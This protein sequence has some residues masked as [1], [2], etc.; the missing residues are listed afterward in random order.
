MP[1]VTDGWSLH[2]AGHEAGSCWSLTPAA[3]AFRYLL[4]QKGHSPYPSWIPF[5]QRSWRGTTKPGRRPSERSRTRPARERKGSQG[6]RGRTSK[7]IGG[8][9]EDLAREKRGVEMARKEAEK[10]VDSLRDQA[11]Y[12]WEQTGPNA[13]GYTDNQRTTQWMPDRA[14]PCTHCSCGSPAKDG[15]RGCP[16]KKS[17][18]RGALE[19][20]T[21]V[22]CGSWCPG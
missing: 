9:P 3:S 18:K 20:S 11:E 22:R 8:F 7:P 17:W 5:R 15:K 14:Q 13:E 2:N 21:A 16:R 6:D 10:Y 19:M 1:K 4:G 12:P